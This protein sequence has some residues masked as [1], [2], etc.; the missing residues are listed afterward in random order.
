MFDWS[1]D[2]SKAR[3]FPVRNSIWLNIGPWLKSGNV[4]CLDVCVQTCVCVPAYEIMCSKFMEMHSLYTVFLMLLLLCPSL[5]TI[6]WDAVTSPQAYLSGLSWLILELTAQSFC[7]VSCIP[8]E[9]SSTN[10]HAPHTKKKKMKYSTE[11]PSKHCS[12]F[13]FTVD[14]CMY[15]TSIRT[16]TYW[17]YDLMGYKYCVVY[18]KHYDKAHLTNH[19]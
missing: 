10:T 5:D 18:V 2:T 6:H 7:S 3:L 19:N 11:L 16:G 12:R 14:L 13:H 9:L 4:F 1:P 17:C 8:S 15:V